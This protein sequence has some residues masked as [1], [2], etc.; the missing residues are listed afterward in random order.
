MCTYR[1]LLYE[2]D[3]LLLLLDYPDVLIKTYAVYE[4]VPFD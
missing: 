3:V 2:S 4:H 1:G